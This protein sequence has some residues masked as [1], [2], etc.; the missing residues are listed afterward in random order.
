MS[1]E[2]S[3][4]EHELDRETEK[5]LEKYDGFLDMLD[6]HNPLYYGA[7][8]QQM[9]QDFTVSDEKGKIDQSMDDLGKLIV[10][11]AAKLK[12]FDIYNASMKQLH[13]LFCALILKLGGTT[14]LRDYDPDRLEP[15]LFRMYKDDEILDLLEEFEKKGVN[16]E[17]IIAVNHKDE[18]VFSNK[19]RYNLTQSSKVDEMVALYASFNENS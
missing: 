11:A 5:L 8:F 2:P 6:Y 10:K 1:A 13:K 18:V 16:P 3:N 15:M 4:Q 7:L 9:F 14:T 12:N 17:N 19:K